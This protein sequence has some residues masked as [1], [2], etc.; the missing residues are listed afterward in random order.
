MTPVGDV[1][2]FIYPRLFLFGPLKSLPN[3][4]SI[5]GCPGRTYFPR[6]LLIEGVVD[7]D[8]G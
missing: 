1:G 5:P 8:A 3:K 7:R 4:K 2:G 6:A